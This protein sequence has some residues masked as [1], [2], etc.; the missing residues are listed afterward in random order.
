LANP[1]NVNINVH[2]RKFTDNLG[3]PASY[4]NRA[5]PKPYGKSKVV[6]IIRDGKYVDPETGREIVLRPGKR[7][8]GVP[9]YNFIGGIE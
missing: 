1:E 2:G 7:N 4:N 9:R 5:T 3:E 8:F 6:G